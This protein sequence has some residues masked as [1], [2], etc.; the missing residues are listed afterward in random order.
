MKIL[1][2]DTSCD[3]CSVALAIDD[4][5]YANREIAS[6]KTHSA[7][8]MYLLDQ[9]MQD[10]EISIQDVDLF[11][12]INGPG[13]FTGTRI[14]VTANKCFAYAGNKK[15]MV[16]NSLEVMAHPYM[17]LK[18]TLL[19]SLINARNERAFSACYLNGTEVIEPRAR[20]LAE[21]F[22]TLIDKIKNGEL[23]CQNI[24]LLT[25]T[26]FPEASQIYANLKQKENLK[27][28]ETTIISKPLAVNALRYAQ[29][30]LQ[31]D[32][33]LHADYKA[34]LTYENDRFKTCDE[35]EVLYLAKTQ[36]ERM[37]DLKEGKE[38]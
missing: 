10:F 37:R 28:T 30:I 18:D 16:F 11:V 15:C 13:S 23:N 35:V 8:Y 1:A 20:Y 24:I 29:E 31:K 4:K 17:K 3:V 19:I 36:A 32:G 34:L 12:L 27:V 21:L 14:A 9:L 6:P 38:S 2:S 25:S 7:N 26:E 22:S 33:L 5:R